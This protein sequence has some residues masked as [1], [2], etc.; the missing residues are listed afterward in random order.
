MRLNMQEVLVLLQ[1]LIL[2]CVIVFICHVQYTTHR[3]VNV[4]M[5][6]QQSTNLAVRISQT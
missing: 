5:Y 2:V 3:M 4:P 6:S 1:I